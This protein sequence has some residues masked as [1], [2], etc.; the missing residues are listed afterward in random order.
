M[1][2]M[3]M[4]MRPPTVFFAVGAQGMQIPCLPNEVVDSRQHTCSTG[5]LARGACYFLNQRHGPPTD[6]I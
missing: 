3:N 6:F 4:R 2:K 1:T 5:R